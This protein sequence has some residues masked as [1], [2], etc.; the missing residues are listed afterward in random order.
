MISLLH[1][2][3]LIKFTIFFTL[4]IFNSALAATAIDIWESKQNQNEQIN[5]EKDAI[6]K[7][8]ILLENA[9]KI[10]V[11]IDE[12]K[13]DDSDLTIIG[14]FDPIENNFNINMWLQ[15]DGQDVVNILERINKLNLSKFSQDLLFQIL[16][17]S[18]YPPR[19]NLTSKEFLKIKI[20]WLIDKKRIEE[21]EILLKNNSL[22]KA[23]K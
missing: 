14:I 9:N 6:I 16:F 23:G 20:D 5:E 4:L 18:A 11:Q 10:S 17:T 2:N 1:L 13:I 15:S 21:L 19:I 7:T 12:E 3:N 22:A 8:P